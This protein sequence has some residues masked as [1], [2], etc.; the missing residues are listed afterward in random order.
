M[1]QDKI[2]LLEINER[3]KTLQAYLRQI[4]YTW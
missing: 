1:H 4:N 3:P 2:L